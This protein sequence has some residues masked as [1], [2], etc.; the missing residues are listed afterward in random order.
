MGYEIKYKAS[1]IHD[2][3]KM[4]KQVAHRI[5]DEFEITILKKPDCGTPL[6]GQFKGMYRL[7]IGD[8]RIIYTMVKNDILVLRIG[9]R[10]KVYK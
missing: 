3:K 8:Y 10:K 9:H 6:K 7:R 1:V 2:L 5:I 4:D